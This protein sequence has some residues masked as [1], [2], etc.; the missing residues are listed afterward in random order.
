MFFAKIVGC[1]NV[2]VGMKAMAISERVRQ[3]RAAAAKTLV[4]GGG[5]GVWPAWFDDEIAIPE[6]AGIIV[7]RGIFS[8]QGVKMSKIL[9]SLFQG[10]DTPS[11]EEALQ[12]AIATILAIRAHVQG[13]VKAKQKEARS[14][15]ELRKLDKAANAI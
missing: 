1:R 14:A 3:R 9:R 8:G 15:K 7:A 13:M 4:L 11:S 6:V 10:K 2:E 12:S 5:E